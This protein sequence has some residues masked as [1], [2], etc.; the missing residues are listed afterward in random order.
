MKI[1]IKRIFLAPLATFY[2]IMFLILLYSYNENGAKNIYPHLMQFQ[3]TEKKSLN[4][5]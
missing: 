5:L 1:S 2:A 4:F 3:L